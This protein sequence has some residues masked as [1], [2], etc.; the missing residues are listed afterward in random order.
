MTDF[1]AINPKEF[2]DNSFCYI[3]K[4]A[5]APLCFSNETLLFYF[6]NREK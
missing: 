2:V 1:G 5:S 6:S 4:G 3:K